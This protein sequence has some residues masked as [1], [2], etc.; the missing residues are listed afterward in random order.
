MIAATISKKGRSRLR[1]IATS[2]YFSR[3][4]CHSSAP[5]HDATT[6]AS[7]SWPASRHAST[8]ASKSPTSSDFL[9]KAAVAGAGAASAA[10]SA[11]RGGPP[12]VVVD[13]G[14]A[15]VSSS[16]AASAASCSAAGPAAPNTSAALRVSMGCCGAAPPSAAAAAAVVSAGS[17]P[18]FS[19]ASAARAFAVSASTSWPSVFKSSSRAFDSKMRRAKSQTRRSPGLVP[20]AALARHSSA[21]PVVE[22][23]STTLASSSSNA[24]ERRA[25]DASSTTGATRTPTSRGPNFATRPPKPNAQPEGRVSQRGARR[26]S[27]SGAP[28]IE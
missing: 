18:F 23:A 14:A 28:A 9:T 5:P 25:N 2:K 16:F 6:K 4:L 11:T 19:A 24:L 13:D 7:A 1:P 21:K 20:V 17:A 8:A 26:W 22:P 12:L 15:T 10:G 3:V 27:L